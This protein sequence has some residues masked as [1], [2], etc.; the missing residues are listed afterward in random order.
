MAN[1]LELSKEDVR[2]FWSKRRNWKAVLLGYGAQLYNLS[3]KSRKG[4]KKK[5]EPIKYRELE[6]NKSERIYSREKRV[7][8][9]LRLCFIEDLSTSDWCGS[10]RD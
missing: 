9:W 10:A 5:R 3:F 8:R 6:Q 2:K 4:A 7:L 1:F